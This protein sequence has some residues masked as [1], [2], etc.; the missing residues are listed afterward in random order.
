MIFSVVRSDLHTAIWTG[1]TIAALEHEIDN[2]RQEKEQAQ[3]QPNN[4]TSSGGFFWLAF[5]SAIRVW[6]NH[7]VHEFLL[8]S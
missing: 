8:S 4:N 7:L 2:A 6:A 1:I 5:V 3:Y